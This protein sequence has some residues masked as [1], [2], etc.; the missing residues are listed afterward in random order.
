MAAVARSIEETR[1]GTRWAPQAGSQRAV[2]KCPTFELL[3]S[4]ERGP[5]KTDAL[6]MDFAQHCGVGYGHHWQGVIFRRTYPELEDIIEKARN[7]FG[8]FFP[9]AKYN[10]A[11][12]LWRWPKGEVL[13][14]RNFEK[15]S[16][17]WKYHG[18]AYPFIGW[19]EL[20][21]WA[22]DACYKSMFSCSRSTR[23]DM[24]R[25]YRAT[26][27]PYGI[28]HSWVKMRWRLDGCP[29]KGQIIT[30]VIRD[31]V[32][33]DGK[34]EPHRVCIFGRLEENKIMLRADPDY[35][36]RVRAS[37]SNPAMADAWMNGSWDIVAGGMFEHCWDKD[38]HIVRPFRIPP[39]S[40]CRPRV[41]RLVG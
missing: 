22:S 25:K 17:Y 20:A 23:A 26:T 11:K 32:D 3:Y 14:F 36:A 15:P 30:K 9:E 40:V 6:L 8:H 10:A 13:K 27:N 38:V 16:D 18:Q 28:G 33:D 4:G 31:A 5:G 21:N 12:S 39:S 35:P 19:E 24:P 41:V 1:G 34:P 2:L 29:R 7:W 37:A